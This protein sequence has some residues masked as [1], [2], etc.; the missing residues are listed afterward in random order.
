MNFYFSYLPD[1]M[2]KVILILNTDNCHDFKTFRIMPV[3]VPGSNQS[4][5]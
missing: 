5:L 3:K 1:N 2:R 4:E